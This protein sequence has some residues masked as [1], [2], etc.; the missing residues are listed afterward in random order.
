MTIDGTASQGEE[1]TAN[2]SA[3]TDADGLGT[4]SYQWKRTVA[5]TETAI[6]GATASTYTLVQ[7]D[8]GAKI[9]VT[10]SR[11]PTWGRHRAKPDLDA[12]PR[13]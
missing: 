5:G 2:T 12:P 13:R 7:A 3:V 9:T 4:F 6:S 8:V 10:V 1:L 11:G